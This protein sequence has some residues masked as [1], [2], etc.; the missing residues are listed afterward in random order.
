[1]S[2][3][4]SRP[5]PGFYRMK[6]V[7]GGVWVPVRVWRPCR[8]TIGGEAEHEWSDACDRHPPLRALIDGHEDAD[9][10]PLWTWLHPITEAEYWFLVEDHA[11][12]R[13]NAPE[14]P[15]ADPQRPVDLGKMKPLF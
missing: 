9:P 14:L 7:K 4:I 10:L 6:R 2:L 11:W 12:A 8:C 15:E 5:E 13:A 3:H 1:M